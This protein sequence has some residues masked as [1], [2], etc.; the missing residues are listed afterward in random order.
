[1]D[2]F[3]LQSSLNWHRAELIL[4]LGQNG[5]RVQEREHVMLGMNS[6]LRLFVIQVR[7]YRFYQAFE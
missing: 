1:M 6:T 2:V 7:V 5:V 3:S 4:G